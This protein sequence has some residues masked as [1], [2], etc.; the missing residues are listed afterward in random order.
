MAVASSGRSA[1]AEHRRLSARQPPPPL[2][3][4]S[5]LNLANGL[6][7]LRLLA[8]LP[9]ALAMQAQHFQLAFWLFVAAGLTDAA[10]GFVAKRFSGVTRLGMMLDP[11]ADKVLLL[12]VFMLL[13]WQG[14]VPSWLLGLVILRDLLILAGA[15]VLRARVEGIQIK[16]SVLGKACTF[17]QILYV[18]LTL[19]AAAGLFRF[20]PMLA[21]TVLPLL[22]L[23]LV[24]LTVASGVAYLIRAIRIVGAGADRI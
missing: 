23:L 8:V 19:G 14:L 7:T 11:I 10:D 15:L 24:A 21:S 1:D 16:P 5:V 22:V 13:A 3:G 4:A 12:A 18:G 9:I 17:T 2:C 20:T 6:T